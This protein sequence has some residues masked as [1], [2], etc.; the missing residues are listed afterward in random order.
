MN[1]IIA[2]CSVEYSGRGRTH[3]PR[4]VRM[5][6]IKRDGSVSVH[7][8]DSGYKPINYMLPPC[9]IKYET[10]PS[11]SID[12]PLQRW[13]VEGKSES[14]TIDIY[15]IISE[16]G[17]TLSEVEPGLK[18]SWT[19]KQ[20][21]SWIAGHMDLVFGEGWQL[22]RREH[23]TGS[24]P[25]DILA[26]NPSGHPVAVEVKRTAHIQSIDQTY[27]YV[28]AMIHSGEHQNVSGLVVALKIKPKTLLLAEQRGIETLEIPNHLFR[29]EE[30]RES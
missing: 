17:F 6:M 26:L 9:V 14:L 28:Q 27:R 16:T 5:I 1:I 8:D 21:Q 7:S 29:N 25:V 24:G 20:L 18:R 3:L 19:E 12:E 13:I 15:E 22:V 4:A 10:L 30:N 2:E 23:P 11:I